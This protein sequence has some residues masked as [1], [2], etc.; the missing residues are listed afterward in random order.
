MALTLALVVTFAIVSYYSEIDLL[1]L[2]L[3]LLI[4]HGVYI[5]L[6][7]ESFQNAPAIFG[8]FVI[9]AVT[10]KR[11]NA[12]WKRRKI[13]PNILSLFAALFA[14][15]I[16]TAITGIDMENS[17]FVMHLYMKGFILTLLIYLFVNR[18][19]EIRKLAGYYLAGA[20]IGTTWIAYEYFTDTFSGGDEWTKRAAGLRED[21]NETAMLMVVAIPLAWY[22]ASRAATPT[23]RVLYYA[24]VAAIMWGM[25]LTGSR[26]GMLST[27]VVL[28]MISMYRP[29]VGKGIGL[30]LTFALIIATAPGVLLDRTDQLI[31]DNNLS[32]DQSVES[33]ANLLVSGLKVISEKPLLGVGPGNIGQAIIATHYYGGPDAEVPTSLYGQKTI[34]A[35]NMFLEF[36]GES[37]I[38]GG[39]LFIL[40]IYLALRGYWRKYRTSDRNAGHFP[41]SYAL[42]SGNIGFLFAG[43]FLSQG[44]ESVLWFLL[45][46]GLA[47]SDLVSK[48]KKRRKKSRRSHS[49]KPASSRRRHKKSASIGYSVK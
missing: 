16:L 32:E 22:F 34:V 47:Y 11:G 45:G 19:S 37:G 29:S 15:M 41:L 38:I 31:N 25:A 12:Y 4:S 14:A 43:L 8:L 49:R 46:I 40:L 36:F 18:R 7:G 26:G 44:K 30:I 27:V 28:L 24:A 3:L 9:L 13:N 17:F 39:T 10:I 1:G 42:L 48:R 33:R 5:R 6:A 2:Y 21:P 20:L 35:H 23:T